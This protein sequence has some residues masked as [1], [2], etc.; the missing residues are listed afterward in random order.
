MSSPLERLA[1]LSPLVASR[2]CPSRPHLMGPEPAR[3]GPVRL[4]LGSKL[5]LNLRDFLSR[6]LGPQV[7]VEEDSIVALGDSSTETVM[8]ELARAIRR[9]SAVRAREAWSECA[10]SVERLMREFFNQGSE[11]R[12]PVV[13]CLR[14]ACVDA[15][16]LEQ[17]CGRD[18]L[19]VHLGAE[20]EA[21]RHDATRTSLADTLHR[22]VAGFRCERAAAQLDHFELDCY[23]ANQQVVFSWRPLPPPGC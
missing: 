2:I 1:T 3:G 19:A 20:V 11:I 6:Q 9:F 13:L 12:G 14:C 7:R 16:P 5:P 17:H 4:H 23:V 8:R 22:A 18:C 10:I 15:G 21:S